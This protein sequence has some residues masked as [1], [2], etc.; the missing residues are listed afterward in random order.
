MKAVGARFGDCRQGAVEPPPL[1]LDPALSRAQLAKLFYY[2][3]G[4]PVARSN[5]KCRGIMSMPRQ[6]SRLSATRRPMTPSLAG[7]GLPFP[8][9]RRLQLFL[10][11][12]HPHK[13]VVVR[14]ARQLKRAE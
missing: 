8:L 13:R 11:E 4:D 6:S 5:W 1:L 2:F 10:C 9:G 3:A 7:G 14:I 12:V